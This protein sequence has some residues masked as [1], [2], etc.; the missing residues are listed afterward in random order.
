MNTTIDYALLV[1]KTDK[2][3]RAMLAYIVLIWG[4]AFLAILFQH[5]NQTE[6]AATL[7]SYAPRTFYWSEHGLYF[8]THYS[9]WL[10][11]VRI[12]FSK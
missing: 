10:I 8:V 12:I 5:V 3:M 11:P 6:L 4:A 7:Y 2:R 1:K 9:A